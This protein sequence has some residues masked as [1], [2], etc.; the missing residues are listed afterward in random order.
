MDSRPPAIFLMGPT[1]CGKSDLAVAL[2]N[3]LPCDLVS[4]DSALIYRGMDIGTAKPD[5][6]LRQRIRHGLIDILDPTQAYSAANFR[7]DALQEMK[8]IANTGRIPL[9]VGGT[10]LYFRKLQEGLSLL[11]SADEAI[12]VRLEAEAQALGWP[13]LHA[14]LAS[15]D[16]V[17]ALRIHPNDPQRIQRALEVYELTSQPLSSLFAQQLQC[18]LPY[19]V[20]KI[21]LSLNDRDKLRARIAQRFDA[22]LQTG[23]IAEVAILRGRGDLHAELPS[24][25]AVGYRH[26]WQYLSGEIDYTHMRERAIIATRQFAK[27]QFTWLRSEKDAQW[28]DAEAPDVLEQVV[29]RISSLI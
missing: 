5:L 8:N 19:R 14:R 23:F 1:A 4:V 26:A 25:R 17:S 20:V 21:V 10:M 12:R 3:V 9:L 2:T 6:A 13:A 22:M 28:F 15:V 16:A 27:R 24:M 18:E 7:E 11:P 29:K